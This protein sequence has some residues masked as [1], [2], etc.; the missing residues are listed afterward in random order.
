M[1]SAALRMEGLTPRRPSRTPVDKAVEDEPGADS[2]GA[3]GICAAGAAAVLRSLG[4]EVRNVRDR[5]L[6]AGMIPGLDDVPPP[7]PRC[8]PVAACRGSHRS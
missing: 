4:F 1:G 7:Y 6:S 3:M 2:L 8:M 5:P